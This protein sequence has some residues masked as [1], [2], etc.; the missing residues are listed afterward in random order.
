MARK[1][2]A[3]LKIRLDWRER[4]RLHEQAKQGKEQRGVLRRGRI[5]E[6]LDKSLGTETVA[7]IVGVSSNAVRSVGW[8]YVEEGLEAA[9]FERERVGAE[10]ALEERQANEVIAMVCSN[11]PEG[12]ARWSV[13]LI[14]EEARK[15][16]IA[17]VGRETVRILL[18]SHDL[19]PWR[20]KNVVRGEAG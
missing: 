7:E 19:K 14:A 6:L 20:K 9:L 2:Y 11:P 15:R 5:L 3:R 10:R 18:Q 13:R 16:K 17:D 8:R 12:Y 1:R 4:K